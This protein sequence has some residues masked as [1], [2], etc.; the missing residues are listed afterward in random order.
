MGSSGEPSKPVQLY[1]GKSVCQLQQRDL[2]PPASPVSKHASDPLYVGLPNLGNSCYQNATLQALLGVAPFVSESVATAL[3][4]PSAPSTAH[5]PTLRALSTLMVLRQQARRRSVS[6][7]V[8]R[9]REVFAAIDPAFR[10]SQMQ[11]ANEFLLRLLD[12][13]KDELDAS[14]RRLPNPVRSSFEYETQES[15]RCCRCG[16]QA[17]R[18]QA[19]ISWFVNVPRRSHDARAPPTLQDA[20]RLSMRPD[21]RELTCEQCGH[22]TCT[23]ATR[24]TRLPRVLILQLNRYVYLS[25]QSRKIRSTV[26][27]PRFISL[28]EYVSDDVASPAAWEC[29]GLPAHSSSLVADVDVDAPVSP[30]VDNTLPAN[31]D[32][33]DSAPITADSPIIPSSPDT[34]NVR[35]NHES[36]ANKLDSHPSDTTVSTAD[37]SQ[38]V[39]SECTSPSKVADISAAAVSVE[40]R[41]QAGESTS[42]LQSPEMTSDQC[43]GSV[44]SEKSTTPVARSAAD[45]T[46]PPMELVVLDGDQ[47][48]SDEERQLQEAIRLSLQ[49]QQNN[50]DGDKLIE[51]CVEDDLSR[52]SVDLAGDDTYRLMAVVSHYG[53]AT[54]SGHYVSDVY[55][56]ARQRWL[57]YDDRRVCDV[58]EDDVIGETHQRNGYIFF[59]MHKS[60]C[61]QVATIEL[62]QC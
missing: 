41:Q 29:Q 37:V 14:E 58:T 38:D 50:E 43:D 56:V 17:Q 36:H 51:Y 27:I 6:S 32:Y 11:D 1:G 13:L 46:T 52:C 2:S 7:H 22:T 28:N 8:N 15:Y 4:L 49:E 59:Y 53:S 30:S 24:V 23:V 26:Q 20:L 19:N 42:P 44:L 60:V 25:E 10:G 12:T 47:P 5:C 62:F 21:E 61:A 39:S 57:H 55:S 34:A 40:Q 31:H 45:P 9:L 54:H 16:H 35:N 3:R 18:R 33:P 48:G